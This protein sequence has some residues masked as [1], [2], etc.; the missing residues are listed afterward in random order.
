MPGMD[1]LPGWMMPLLGALAAL[2]V[3]L[4]LAQ[5]LLPRMSGQPV[6]RGPAAR[7]ARAKLSAAVARGSDTKRSADE[8]AQAFVEA[9]REA[10]TQLGRPRLAARY[11]HYALE[12]APAHDEVVRFAIDAMTAGKRWVGLERALWIALDRASDDAT[13]ELARVAL[14]KLYAGAL[15]RPERARVLEGLRRGGVAS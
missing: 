9:G 11:A 8:R 15:H 12:L 13:F 14:A 4:V 6:A 3:L 7:A 5:A 10:L 2:L 1:T